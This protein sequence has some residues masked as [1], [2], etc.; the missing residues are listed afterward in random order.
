MLEIWAISALYMYLWKLSGIF[1]SFGQLYWNMMMNKANIENAH[2]IEYSKD[3]NMDDKKK[4][5]KLTSIEFQNVWFSYNKQKNIFSALN[6][7]IQSWEKIALIGYSGS[8]KT[9][10]LK[11]IHGLY[12]IDSGK[13]ILNQT[14]TINDISKIDLNTILVPQ[15]PELFVASIKQNITFGLS[16]TNAQIKKYT[17]MACFSEVIN[18]LK[19]W[20]QSTINEK[21]VN[22]SWWQK[23]R[24][25]LARALLFAQKKDVVLLDESTSS[26]DLINEL[27]IYKN[28]LQN[29]KN[30]TII[31]SIHKM[32]LLKFFDRIIIIDSWKIID[33]GSFEYLLKNNKKFANMWRDFSEKNL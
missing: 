15:E 8:W 18:S 31:A 19:N 26:V 28:I 3:F 2:E 32:N 4:L 12:N 14:D 1:G 33:D 30:K 13:I 10:L 11:V 22:L 17:D 16:Y 7:K 27:Q 21:W 20:L 29:F 6:L 5:K 24:L 25:A 23:Q 9:T